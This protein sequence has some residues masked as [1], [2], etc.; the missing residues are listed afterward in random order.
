M[1]EK[2]AQTAPHLTSDPASGSPD[3]A[4]RLDRFAAL[5]TT[6]AE[7]FALV[8]VL[9]IMVV[10]LSNVVDII[11]RNFFSTSLYGLN[12]INVLAI[13]I[14]VTACLPYGL[15]RGSS[16]AI[17]MVRKRVGPVWALLLDTIAA[18]GVLIFFGLL[19]WRLGE[20]AQAMQ[21]SGQTTVLSDIPKAPFYWGMTLALVL[22][23]AVQVLMTAVVLRDLR[24]VSN[25]AAVTVV[26]TITVL[27]IW[28][29]AGFPAREAVLGWAVPQNPLVL[30]VLFFVAMW[31]LILMSVPIGVSMG[32]IGILGTAIILSGPLS[33]EV[34]GTESASFVA[35]DGLSV[36]P[37]FLL[38]GAF[39]SLAGIGTDLYRLANALVGHL[40]GGLAYASILAC[41]AFGMLT[42][43]SVATQMSIGK[44][45][46][47]EMQD[48]T[49]RPELAAGS[50]AAGGTLGQLIPPSSALILFAVLTE[51]SV[52]QLFI[53]A[54]IPGFL[55]AGLYMAAVTVWLMIRP[56]DAAKRPR[57]GWAE[58][59][60]AAKGS[61]S[62]L[63]L[64]GLV[65]GGIYFGFFTEL[66][67]GAV[68]A[69]G[70]FLLAVARGKFNIQNFW[71][72]MANATVSLSMMYSLIFGVT[73]LS[74]FFGIAGLPQ[75]FIGWVDGLGMSNLGVVLCLVAAYL[76]L[77]TAM[78]AFAMMMITIPIF[79]PLV[80]SLGYDPIWWGIMTLICMEAG[81]IS[82]PFGLNIF[83]INAIDDRISIGQVYRGVL[84]FFVS[85]LVKIAL[86]LA[87]PAL[88]TWL[89]SLM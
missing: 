73:M 89:P 43:S 72:A 11:L 41:A 5:A 63:L 77:G 54:I 47:K 1:A 49:Y 46:M 45:A 27:F 51:Q 35:R 7:R 28:G 69:V 56:Q 80:T 40:R 88:V 75:A 4:A 71:P 23:A 36:L 81:Q 32:L 52:G 14:A 15:A 48:N 21:I 82:P 85:S 83:V 59:A 64:L 84:P 29:I 74:F 26:V 44:I 50:V 13:A 16:L 17:D 25:R 8:A 18:C 76:I 57:G 58:V 34:L 33:L 61:W 78:D 55:A 86:L 60:A 12:E 6:I 10:A 9:A 67:A 65:L 37:L 79:V 70:G 31:V 2:S 22:A 66:E 39:A 87:F 19:A 62:V 68:G 38:M 42:G 24:A 30:S 20:A 53:G 3:H